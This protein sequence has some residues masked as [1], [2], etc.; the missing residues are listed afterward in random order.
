MLKCDGCNKEISESE[1]K[2]MSSYRNGSVSSINICYDC[3]HEMINNI[4]EK[5][6]VIEYSE[7]K[8]KDNFIEVVAKKLNKKNNL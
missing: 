5:M 4:I 1:Y 2:T 8:N 3:Y 7:I 6:C